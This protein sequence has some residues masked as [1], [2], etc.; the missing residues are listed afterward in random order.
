MPDST[1]AADGAK[2]ALDRAVAATRALAVSATRPPLRWL[3]PTARNLLV[4]L[5]AAAASYGLTRWAARAEAARHLAVGPFL[6]L[7]VVI[8]LLVWG[9][10]A[11]ARDYLFQPAVPDPRLPRQLQLGFVLCYG[12]MLVMLARFVLARGH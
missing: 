10:G 9:A 2:A 7:L 12:A 6:A 11:V 3:P 8:P 5:P 1:E 4:W